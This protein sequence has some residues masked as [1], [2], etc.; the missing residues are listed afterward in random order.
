M[1]LIWYNYIKTITILIMRRKHH[2]HYSN[3]KI[4]NFDEFCSLAG[5]IEFNTILWSLPINKNEPNSKTRREIDKLWHTPNKSSPFNEK[6]KTISKQVTANKFFADLKEK[7]VVK[8][9]NEL[10]VNNH[11]DRVNKISTINDLKECEA[12]KIIMHSF[13]AWIPTDDFFWKDRDTRERVFKHKYFDIE[14]KKILGDMQKE[15]SIGEIKEGIDEFFE[16]LNKP[17]SEKKR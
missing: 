4:K 10:V 7:E 9:I 5:Y 12:V 17:L 3:N 6:F 13:F 14:N 2:T 16:E 8:F 1:H 15:K 11:I